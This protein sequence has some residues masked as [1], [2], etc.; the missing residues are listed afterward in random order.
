M[1]LV[2][3][4]SRNTTHPG[5]IRLPRRVQSTSSA[6]R[7]AARARNSSKRREKEEERHRVPGARALEP[8]VPAD[9]AGS[10][11]P[12]HRAVSK[13]RCQNF[14]LAGRRSRIQLKRSSFT[15]LRAQVVQYGVARRSLRVSADAF[16]FLQ[17]FR[18]TLMRLAN[19]AGNLNR[20][21]LGTS[22]MFFLHGLI[23]STWLSR[24]PAVQ[25]RLG[26]NARAIGPG[27]ARER[28]SAR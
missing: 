17:V 20:A 16:L 6:E 28:P 21:R 19:H 14:A 22:V 12:I 13:I 2:V 9:R 8:R 3:P 26:L 15:I 10:C 27:A 1:S 24:I 18:C 23:V 7:I 4:P 25:S 11:L 5:L